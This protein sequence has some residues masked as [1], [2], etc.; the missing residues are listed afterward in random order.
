[1]AVSAIILLSTLIMWIMYLTTRLP[2]ICSYP[3]IAFGAK[4]A[5]AEDMRTTLD[6]L[7]NGTNWLVINR[8]ADVKI[9]V[10]EQSDDR[11]RRIIIST[12]EVLPLSG[13]T[14]YI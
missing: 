11:M 12:A 14:K 13:L 6:G 2:N 10:G 7:S 3:E 1:M 9:K 8:L 4:L 5:Y